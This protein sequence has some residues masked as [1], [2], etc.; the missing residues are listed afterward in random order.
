MA[1]IPCQCCG[2]SLPDTWNWYVCDKCGAAL[3]KKTV[4]EAVTC[5]VTVYANNDIVMATSVNMSLCYAVACNGDVTISDPYSSNTYDDRNLYQLPNAIASYNG[6]IT[7]ATMYGK[8]AA[9]FYAPSGNSTPEKTVGNVK[10]DGFYQ[11]VWGSIIGDTVTVDTFYI[12]LHRFNNWRT[13]D[14]QIAESGNVYL[15]SKEEYD[16]YVNNVDEAFMTSGNTEDE[17][18]GGA[19]LFFDKDILNKGEVSGGGLEQTTN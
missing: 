8:I 13:M 17:T 5:P 6:N 19:S 3:S 11:E 2:Q 18:K 10:L 15:I 4:R 1:W 7:Y 14:L 12:N 9:L 16:K